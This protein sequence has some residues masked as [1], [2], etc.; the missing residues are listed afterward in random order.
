MGIAETPAT[1]DV[2]ACIVTHKSPVEDVARA[3]ES[4]LSSS[5][6]TALLVVDNNSGDIYLQQLKQALPEGV[7]LV[8]SKRND[9]F[10]AGNNIGIAA[11]PPS[12]YVL[13]LNPDIVIHDGTL[14]ILVT[15]LDDHLD[16]GV[17]SPKILYEDGSLQ[18]LN[19]REPTLLDLFLRRF[20]PGIFAQLPPVK[21]RLEYYAMLD[22]GYDAPCP[23][24]FMTGCF[25]LFRKDVLDRVG[26][27]DERFFMYLEDADLTKRVNAISQAIYVPSATVTHGWRRGSHH[28]FKLFLVMLHSI[29]VYFNKWGWRWW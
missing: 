15:Y 5:L 4:F 16:V 1:C 26:G 11:L 28:S 2:A 23:V 3:A 25:M 10:G 29:W 21:K 12:R 17:V 9:G 8:A 24:E 27:F 6:N 22:V 7:K 13:L 18:P 14:E 19:K 20:M